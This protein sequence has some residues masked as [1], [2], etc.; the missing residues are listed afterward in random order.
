MYVLGKVSART[1][2]AEATT[3]AT[4]RMSFFMVV[5]LSGSVRDPRLAGHVRVGESVGEDW[6][7]RGDDQSDGEDELLHGG[8]PF[9]ID[10]GRG[11]L[12]S[13]GRPFRSNTREMGAPRAFAQ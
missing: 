2:A 6:R 11:I 10:A 13:T 7:G 8:S 5:L 9:D 1:G 12:G 4:A 3:R